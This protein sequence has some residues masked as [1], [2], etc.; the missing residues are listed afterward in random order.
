MRK[1]NDF[2]RYKNILP[3]D[4]EIF[5]VYQP[6]IGWKSK[7][8]SN[9]QRRVLNSQANSKSITSAGMY[10]SIVQLMLLQ[11]PH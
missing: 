1:I 6:M 5:G 2:S 8:I 10:P 7:R 4:S 11:V 9:V 3:Y